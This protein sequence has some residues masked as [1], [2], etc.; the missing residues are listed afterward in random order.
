MTEKSNCN[1]ERFMKF[2]NKRMVEYILAG[3]LAM[4]VLASCG[5][6]A[7][8]EHEHTA[9]GGWECNA[10]EHWQVCE[11]GELLNKAAHEI[12]DGVGCAVCGSEIW[13]NGDGSFS[14]YSYSAY[15]D[16]IRIASYDPD[17][18][19]SEEYLREM[20][21]DAEGNPLRSKI[22]YSGVFTEEAEYGLQ[23]DGCYAETKSV[24][25]SEDGSYVTNEYNTYGDLIRMVSYNADG[26]KSAEESS[27]YAKDSDGNTFECKTTSVY[28]EMGTSYTS[29]YNEFGDQISVITADLD[30]NVIKTQHI[31]Y[32]YDEEGNHTWNKI[33]VNDVLV[34]EVTGYITIEM[35][36]YT[37]RVP[38]CEIHYN[39]DGSK[40]V[41]TPNEIG[42]VGSE[43]Y[44]NTDG[45][46][47]LTVTYEYDF[48]EDGNRKSFRIYEDGR[49]V[50][51]SEYRIDE[52]YGWSYEAKVTEY[53]ENGEVISVTEFDADGNEIT[54]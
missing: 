49:L 45:T 52:E 47:R 32:G 22:Y 50:Q 4:T 44:Y 23:A 19:E 16:L 38:E 54:G 11:D 7:P 46:I 28:Y 37:M 31:E 14:V 33:Y 41:V 26:T 1:E 13:D 51:D 29:E 40:M 24:Y 17:G 2:M 48:F 35:D 30:G 25:Y 36:D 21:Y 15:G 12:V 10:A 27:E 34:E 18:V 39:E 6:E 20:E 9:V 5:S 43:T 3:V 8:A 53:G 42:D